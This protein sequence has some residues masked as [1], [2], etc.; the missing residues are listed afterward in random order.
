MDLSFILPK[1][2]V[3]ILGVIAII[4]AKFVITGIL[5]YPSKKSRKTIKIYEAKNKRV[6]AESSSLSDAIKSITRPLSRFVKLSPIAKDEMGKAL[7]ISG[8]SMTPEEYTV[9]CYGYAAIFVGAGLLLLLIGFIADLGM[10]LYLGVIIACV[11]PIMAFIKRRSLTKTQQKAMSGV[12]G[13]LARFVFFLRA[14]M[15][16][17]NES[18]LSM[19]ERY[20][21]YD[22]HFA[23]ELARTIADAKTSNFDGAMARFDQRMNSDKLKMVIHGLVAANNGDN[24][25]VYFSMLERD[26]EAYEIA[27][28]KQNIQ[29]IPKRMRLPKMLMYSAVAFALFLPIVMQIIDSFKGIFG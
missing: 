27:L 5:P 19:I 22:E 20:T 11:G 26:F 17:G 4:G 10:Y 13:E 28:L 24:V 1:I 18:I 25:D 23:E 2:V 8:I 16:A 12:D 7:Q 29:T 6:E 14:A 9:F 3:I 21:A 15:A